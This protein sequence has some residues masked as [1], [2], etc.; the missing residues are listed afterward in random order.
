M[1]FEIGETVW[2][3][4]YISFEPYLWHA[5]TEFPSFE[6][7]KLSYVK[8]CVCEWNKVFGRILF[9]ERDVVFTFVVYTILWN[10]D[11][12]CLLNTLITRAIHSVK[13]AAAAQCSTMRL[14]KLWIRTWIF[15]FTHLAWLILDIN[16]FYPQIGIWI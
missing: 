8:L 12:I 10:A 2:W 3:T 15:Y 1:E 16:C 5:A 9:K 13:S 7:N 11:N 14:N 6:W 4:R